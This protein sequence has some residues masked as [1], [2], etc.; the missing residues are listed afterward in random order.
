MGIYIRTG[1]ADANGVETRFQA[2][3]HFFPS[4]VLFF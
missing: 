2:K 3:T 1:I 4:G